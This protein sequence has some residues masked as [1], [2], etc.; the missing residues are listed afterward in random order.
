[1][2]E[3]EVPRS[4]KTLAVRHESMSGAKV[5]SDVIYVCLS[6]QAGYRS[7]TLGAFDALL[8]LLEQDFIIFRENC[9]ERPELIQHLVH[10]FHALSWAVKEF[11][12]CA[13][14]VRV[15]TDLQETKLLEPV[16]RCLE[17]LF[18]AGVQ[19]WYDLLRVHFFQARVELRNKSVF[20]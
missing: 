18:E 20:H 19:E 15:G 2:N 10:L 11:S 14:F 3:F 17:D 12:E 5:M 4:A 16:E 1:M 9:V 7:W 13:I 6:S 8:H